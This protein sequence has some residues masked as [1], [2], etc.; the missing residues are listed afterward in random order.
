MSR[1]IDHCVH[2]VRDLSAAADLYARLGFTVGVRN[3][4]PWGTHNY[5][6]QLPGFFVELLTLAEPAK[7]GD[8]GFSRLFGTYTGEFLK[9]DEGLSLMILQSDNAAADEAAFR[10]AGIAASET[11]R[12]EREGKRPD[13]SSVKVAFSL[14]FAEDKRAPKT[15]FAACQQHYPENFWNPAFQRHANSVARIAGAVVVAELPAA[16]RAF[17][18]A[19]TGSDSTRDDGEGFAIATPRGEVAVMTPAAFKGRFGVAAPDAETS[20]RL[21]A[22]RFGARDVAALDRALE[23]S[24]LPVARVNG[25]F[26]LGPESAMGAA[27]VFQV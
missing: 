14:A 23:Q 25:A 16:H 3:Q 2:A 8:D 11:M 17:M 7:L 22:L 20:A 26:V 10:A 6:I 24:G 9:R 15:H 19:F 5:L 13:G 21:A 18:L 12:F 27:L 4:H 1:G